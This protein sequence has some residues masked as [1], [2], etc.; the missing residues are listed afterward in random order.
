MICTGK[1]KP[2]ILL[3]NL[4][5]SSQQ[6]NSGRRQ[7]SA[8]P[9]QNSATAAPAAPA[10]QRKVVW[11]NHLLRFS[12]TS[13]AASLWQDQAWQV[14]AGTRRSSGGLSPGEELTTKLQFC[15]CP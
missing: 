10:A 14:Y 12:I 13:P 2:S 1:I 5:S 8:Q 6:P 11:V 3:R 4:S 9:V 7:A 15:C